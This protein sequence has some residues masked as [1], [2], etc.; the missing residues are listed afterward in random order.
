MDDQSCLPRLFAVSG[1]DD[2]G[3]TVEVGWGM[4]FPESERT[5]MC[6][7]N[8]TTYRGPSATTAAQLMQRFGLTSQLH[9][10]A[11]PELESSIVLELPG[12]R[13]ELT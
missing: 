11:P 7:A 4:E 1:I 12:T 13:P 6:L 3:N 8:G 2:T 9:R 5:F 10:F